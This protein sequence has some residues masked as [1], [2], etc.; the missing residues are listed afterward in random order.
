MGVVIKKGVKK[1]NNDCFGFLQLNFVKKI[2]PM[3]NIINKYASDIIK[4]KWV[5]LENW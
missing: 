2:D 4:T 1:A 5:F 3:P